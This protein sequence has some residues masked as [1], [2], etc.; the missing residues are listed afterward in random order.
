MGGRQEPLKHVNVST[1]AA[2]KWVV[3]NVSVN[4]QSTVH[5]AFLLYVLGL[6]GLVFEILH[7]GLNLPGLVGLVL[8]VLSLVVFDTLPINVAVISGSFIVFLVV[9]T[10]LFVRAERNR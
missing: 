5:V 1:A 10:I 9:G 8:F 4:P 3:I 7:P 6:A 2:L